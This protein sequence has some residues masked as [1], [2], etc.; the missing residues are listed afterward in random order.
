MGF[1]STLRIEY[2]TKLNGVDTFN[3]GILCYVN[4][5]CRTSR[6]YEITLKFRVIAITI[7][8]PHSFINSSRYQPSFWSPLQDKWM[9]PQ[10]LW[11]VGVILYGLERIHNLSAWKIVVCCYIHPNQTMKCGHANTRSLR[12]L[13]HVNL[14]CTWLISVNI[15]G[16]YNASHSHFENN[17]YE[18]TQRP[19]V[20]SNV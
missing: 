1:R 10:S 3:L 13:T 17:A 18:I 8:I 5:F 4:W 15:C 9:D 19:R 14:C 20:W 2:L 11:T 12:K 7:R 16:L 6:F